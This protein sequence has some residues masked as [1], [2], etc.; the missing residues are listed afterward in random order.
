MT[1]CNQVNELL[2]KFQQ[3]CRCVTGEEKAIQPSLPKQMRELYFYKLKLVGRGVSTDAENRDRM[4]KHPS[5]SESA[6]EII[7][8]LTMS[9]PRSRSSTAH[10][11][12]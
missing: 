5:T 2:T 4:Y 9:T 8:T 11:S 12:R 10:M 1:T 3:Q 6:R 7:S